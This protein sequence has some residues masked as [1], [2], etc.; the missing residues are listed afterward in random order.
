MQPTERFRTNAKIVIAILLP[1]LTYFSTMNLPINDRSILSAVNNFLWIASGVYFVLYLP[2]KGLGLRHWVFKVLL[3]L[4]VFSMFLTA[5]NG[6]MAHRS[7]I[8]R[9]QQNG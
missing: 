2:I 1:V 7:N 9:T 8:I 4:L 5:F 3:V 6:A